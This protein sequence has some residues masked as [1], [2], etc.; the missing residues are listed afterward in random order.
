[1]TFSNPAAAKKNMTKKAASI[2]PPP[3]PSSSSP[4]RSISIVGEAGP[5]AITVDNIH[6]GATSEDIKASESNV[7]QICELTCND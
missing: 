5:A 6:P 3:P 7:K 4:K 1:V 2:P